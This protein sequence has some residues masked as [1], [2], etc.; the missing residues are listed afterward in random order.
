LRASL[1]VATIESS[2]PIAA[3]SFR[4]AMIPREILKKIRQIE[5]RTNR[6]VTETRVTITYEADAEE[7]T[8]E[9]V[10]QKI[11]DELPVP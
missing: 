11:F 8:S 3:C 6:I 10:I 7:K 9:T 2:I 4:V 5:I 1:A